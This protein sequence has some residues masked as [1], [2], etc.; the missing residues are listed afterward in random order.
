M[1]AIGKAM[2]LLTTAGITRRQTVAALVG[3]IVAMCGAVF[4]TN[5][6][7]SIMEGPLP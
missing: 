3:L 2:A 5:V 1:S 4:A 6:L 7:Q